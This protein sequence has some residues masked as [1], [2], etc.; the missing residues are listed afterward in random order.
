MRSSYFSSQD[1]ACS[2]AS[3]SGH[4]LSSCQ[5]ASLV[6]SLTSVP[7]DISN[8]TK[9]CVHRSDLIHYLS[10]KDKP[11]PSEVDSSALSVAADG[12]L[13]SAALSVAADGHP[14]SAAIFVGENELLV[15][16]IIHEHR[17]SS[18]DIL[19]ASDEDQNSLKVDTDICFFFV[20]IL[21]QFTSLWTI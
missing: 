12:H 20:I 4:N 3:P 11:L 18:A 17:H 10:E 2:I 6:S 9:I 1:S 14:S 16:E 7:T 5:H 19:N 15:N 13:S 21:K 8:L